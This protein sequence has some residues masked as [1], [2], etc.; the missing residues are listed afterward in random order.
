MLPRSHHLQDF[1][2]MLCNYIEQNDSNQLT[3]YLDEICSPKD[4]SEFTDKIKLC[5]SKVLAVCKMQ[6]WRKISHVSSKSAVK[7][8]YQVS[9]NAKEHWYHWTGST[10]WYR[11]ECFSKKKRAKELFN[12]MPYI[13]ISSGKNKGLSVFLG[14]AVG[15]SNIHDLLCRSLQ[16]NVLP[17][18]GNQNVGKAVMK[19]ERRQGRGFL[20]D[21]QTTI[22]PFIKWKRILKWMSSNKT[23]CLFKML[24][25]ICRW[26][27]FLFA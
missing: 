10:G 3:E 24:W 4:R 26:I 1:D 7:E 5:A 19:A 8:A 9:R 25:Y 22:W 18:K 27:W 21:S 11:I 13:Y 2:Y 15:D 14:S 12:S 17:V 23:F 20:S 16:V 6:W